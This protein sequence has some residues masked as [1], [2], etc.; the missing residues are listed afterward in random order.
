MIVLSIV[1]FFFYSSE[2]LF[3]L[4]MGLRIKVAYHTTLVFR[5]SSITK[6]F[7]LR[8]ESNFWEWRENAMTN[9]LLISHF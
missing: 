4:D 9:Y 5:T 2:S 3:D 1:S 8:D 6:D 7:T